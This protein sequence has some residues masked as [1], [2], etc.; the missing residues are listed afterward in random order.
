MRQQRLH[1][2]DFLKAALVPSTPPGLAVHTVETFI[3]V[4]RYAYIPHMSA[5]L[6]TCRIFGV[7]YC[8]TLLLSG[9]YQ[10]DDCHALEESSDETG[11]LEVITN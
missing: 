2:L 10:I 3:N 11:C 5:E 9:M 4:K 1:T 8:D 6:T 7:D